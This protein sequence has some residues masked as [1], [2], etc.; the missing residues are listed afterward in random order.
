MRNVDDID[1]SLREHEGRTSVEDEN[2]A[3]SLL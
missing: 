1:P 3:E 2:R